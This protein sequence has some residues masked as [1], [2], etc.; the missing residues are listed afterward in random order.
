[1]AEIPIQ[2]DSRIVKMTVMTPMGLPQK[3]SLVVQTMTGRVGQLLE[4]C[5][6]MSRLSTPTKT[7]TAMATTQT[8]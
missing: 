6:L 7:K 4:I 8:A 5:S 2:M 3:T 1:M